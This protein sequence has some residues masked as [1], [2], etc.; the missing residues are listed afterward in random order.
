MSHGVLSGLLK[1]WD[2]IYYFE[3]DHLGS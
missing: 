3:R 1:R 2:I